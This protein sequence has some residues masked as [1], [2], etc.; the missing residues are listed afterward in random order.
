MVVF[1]YSGDSNFK[2]NVFNECGVEICYPFSC[3]TS[4]N[5]RIRRNDPF[6]QVPTMKLTDIET[7]KLA[8]TFSFNAIHNFAGLHDIVIQKSHLAQNSNYEVLSNLQF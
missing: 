8:A 3:P 4:A 7:D 5:F 2:L 6:V 1:H